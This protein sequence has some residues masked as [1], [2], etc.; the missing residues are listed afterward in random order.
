MQ[1]EIELA[2]ISREKNEKINHLK[3]DIAK[4]Q[5]QRNEIHAKWLGEN[6]NLKI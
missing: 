6:K 2:A 3:E 5:E 4:I 1:L